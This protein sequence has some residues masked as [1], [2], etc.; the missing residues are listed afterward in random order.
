[1]IYK[2]YPKLDEFLTIMKGLDQ[3]R[4]AVLLKGVNK[5]MV[6]QNGVPIVPPSKY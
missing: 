6:K 3:I 5:A 4:G 1:M 2:E